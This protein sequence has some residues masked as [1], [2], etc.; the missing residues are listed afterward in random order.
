MQAQPSPPP[1][2][3]RRRRLPRRLDAVLGGSALV[4]VAGWVMHLA[5]LSQPLWLGVPALAWP[6]AL[7]AVVLLL[8]RR[9]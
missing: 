9:D 2:T 4:A 1:D 8:P 5:G 3:P 7:L 6:L